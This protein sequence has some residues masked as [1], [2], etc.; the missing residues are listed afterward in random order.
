MAMNYEK[1]YIVLVQEYKKP[2]EFTREAIYKNRRKFI[3]Y[4]Y[5]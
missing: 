4:S 5:L 1:Y 2:R 3:D